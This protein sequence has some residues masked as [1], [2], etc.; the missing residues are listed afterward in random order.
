M[1]EI[2]PVQIPWFIAGPAIGLL[3]A[4]LYAVANRPLGASGAYVQTLSL[5]RTGRA[6]EPWRAWYFGGILV[7]GLI[8]GVLGHATAADY[9]GLAAQRRIIEFFD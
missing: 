5:V 8:V 7:G 9:Y 6:A 4:G 3:V 2:L 1:L